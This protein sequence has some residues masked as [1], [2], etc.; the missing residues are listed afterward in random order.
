M[1]LKETDTQINN[2]A[3]QGYFLHE[4]SYVDPG[5]TVGAG[6]KVWHFCHVLP[7]AIIGERCVLGQNVCVL[8]TARIGNGVKIQNNVTIYDSVIL[9]DEVFCGPSCVFTNVINPRAFIERKHE[10]RPTVVRRGASLGANCTVVCGYEICEYALIAAGAVVTSDV[11]SHALMMGVPARRA[12]WVCVC[13]A[14]LDFAQ[15]EECSCTQCAARYRLESE[16][17][18]ACITLNDTAKT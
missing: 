6:T 9:E 15:G 8:G 12:G 14:R 1:R 13:G 7:G 3:D 2:N 18:I 5:A 4:S 16:D 10:Y 11:P 17:S